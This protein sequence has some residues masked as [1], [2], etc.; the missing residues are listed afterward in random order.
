MLLRLSNLITFGGQIAKLESIRKIYS[1]HFNKLIC[2]MGTQFVLS[3][4]STVFLNQSF[5]LPTTALI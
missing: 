4:I 1:N 2:V 3:E 5:I